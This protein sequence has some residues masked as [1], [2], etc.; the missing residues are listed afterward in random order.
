MGGPL[1]FPR[2]CRNPRCQL[3]IRT[4]YWGV[5]VKCPGSQGP[6]SQGLAGEA[7][8]MRWGKTR[9]QLPERRTLICLY[10]LIIPVWQHDFGRNWL[11]KIV[12]PCYSVHTNMNGYILW[13]PFWFQRIR[14][15][16]LLNRLITLFT[17]MRLLYGRRSMIK[18]DPFMWVSNYTMDICI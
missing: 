12:N 18:N 15:S 17:T 2:N 6:V 10:F 8:P 7:T 1:S 3:G 11:F 13:D 14:K 4:L 9:R 5:G 16:P